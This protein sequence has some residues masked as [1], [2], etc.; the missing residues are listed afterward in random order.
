MGIDQSGA[1]IGTD[2]HDKELA[3]VISYGVSHLFVSLLQCG[4]VF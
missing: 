2:E 4:T 1:R 3:H